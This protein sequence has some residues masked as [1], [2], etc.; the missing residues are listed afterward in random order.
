MYI[1]HYLKCNHFLISIIVLFSCSSFERQGNGF[2]EN[3]LPSKSKFIEFEINKIIVTSLEADTI[4]I[5]LSFKNISDVDIL[6]VEPNNWGYDILPFL[7]DS[8]G[9]E[10][11]RSFK[12]KR[13]EIRE[14]VRA[15]AVG[16]TYKSIFIYSLNECYNLKI[17]YSYA[18]RFMY[19]GAILNSDKIR[20]A[21]NEPIYSNTIDVVID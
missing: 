11:Q 15:L 2:S 9:T 12:I 8:S 4:L 18:L 20:I 19:N 3:S 21:N 7:Y 16:E 14:M 17:G 13:G 5:N 6:L 1:G 10:L